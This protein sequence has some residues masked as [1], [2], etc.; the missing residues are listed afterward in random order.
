MLFLF[1]CHCIGTCKAST[2]FRALQHQV[3]LVLSNDPKPEPATFIVQCMY[4]S[5]LFEDHSQGFTH[6]IISALRR[7]L[8][9]STTTTEDSLEVKDLV[10]HLLVDIIWGQID[11]D[12]KIVLKLLEIF[13]VKLTNVEKAMCQ[14]KEKHD[15]SCG[16]AKEFVEQYIVELVKSQLYMTAVTLIEQFSIHQYGQSFLL[17][18]IQSNQFKA[19]EKW[20]TFMGKPML[21]TLV[22]EFIERNML[23]NAY[24]I[25]KKNNLKQDFPDVYKR[26]KER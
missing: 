20:A 9:R 17:D 26:C 6:L 4:V 25:I 21:S 10:A 8:K 7:F 18:M 19:A 11:H 22:E 14:I 3:H 13:D 1:K 12:E 15:L 23:K 2:K 24:E 16:T 5:P